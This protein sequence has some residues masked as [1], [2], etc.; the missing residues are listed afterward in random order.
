MTSGIDGDAMVGFTKLPVAG[1]LYIVP[2]IFHSQCDTVAPW[3]NQLR[4]SRYSKSGN[5]K[6]HELKF[7]FVILIIILAV[8]HLESST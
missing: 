5:F 8:I 2:G 6:D 1:I 7:Q 4:F 3:G